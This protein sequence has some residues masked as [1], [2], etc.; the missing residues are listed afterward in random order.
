MNQ[1]MS[2][3]YRNV[4]SH[5]P[6]LASLL[7]LSPPPKKKLDNVFFS[8]YFSFSQWVAYLVLKITQLVFLLK[9]VVSH[10]GRKNKSQNQGCWRNW[11]LLPSIMR[12]EALLWAL[13]SPQRLEN[14]DHIVASPNQP[15]QTTKIIILSSHSKFICKNP[16]KSKCKFLLFWSYC[17]GPPNLVHSSAS[18]DVCV[19][20]T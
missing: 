17:V 9:Y 1:S 12:Y 14:L 19:V 5:K 13:P 4:Q 3:F 2:N 8:W 10:F 7:P 6:R 16:K 20:S 11:V 18:T 15:L